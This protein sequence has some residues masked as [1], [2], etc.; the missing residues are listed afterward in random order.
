LLPANPPFTRQLTRPERPGPI[1]RLQDPELTTRVREALG[2]GR[3]DQVFA[4]G[5]GLS[6]RQ[7]ATAAREHSTGAPAS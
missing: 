7:A 1:A 4:A 5:S 3:F 6:Q 2:A